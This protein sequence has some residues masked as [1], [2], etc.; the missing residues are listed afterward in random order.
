MRLFVAVWPTTQVREVLEELPQ[1]PRKGVRW[2]P[3]RNWHVTLLFLG[4]MEDKAAAKR[5]LSAIDLG[6]LGKVEAKLGPVTGLLGR[7]ILQVPVSGL[8]E[9]ASRVRAAP[10][11][12]PRTVVSKEEASKEEAVSKG[13]APS[14]QGHLTL[15][16][17]KD[18]SGIRSLAG[19]LVQARWEVRSIDLV[20]SELRID[21]ARYATIATRLLP[22]EADPQGRTI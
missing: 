15:A 17:A 22:T 13:Q 14:F 19:R 4:E 16:R 12:A 18:P 6:S 20:S 9:L 2:V 1:P 8:D 5:A 3:A 7:H 11:P 10:W 21:G